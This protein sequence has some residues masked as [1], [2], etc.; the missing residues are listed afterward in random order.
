MTQGFQSQ[1]NVVQAPAVEGD[2]ASTNPRASVLAG[3]FGLVAGPNGVTVGRFAWIVNPDDN[4]GAPAIVNNFGLGAPAGFVHR[5]QQ[6]L[7]TAFLGNASML[8]PKGF[9]VTLID[10]GDVWIKN[11]GAAVARP[12]MKAYASFADGTVNFAATGAATTASAAS[13]SVAAATSSVTGS[14]ADTILTVT[15]VGSGTLVNGTTL[16][17]SGVTSGTKIVSQLTGTAGGIGTYAVD[18]PQTVA[19][20]TISG[21]YGILTLGTVTGGPFIVGGVISGTG[22]DAGTQVTQLL[23]GTGG[24]GSTMA[25]DSN[26]VVSS[27]TITETLNYETKWFARSTGAQNELVKISSYP[28]G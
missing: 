24:T 21:T 9:P 4:D 5:A 3:Q 15:A 28:L 10:A 13:S 14:I 12:G 11:S 2:F 1:V 20:T 19:S 23:T 6:G 7:I 26:T 22:V 16:S 27:T 17:G 8:V 18:K 25:V